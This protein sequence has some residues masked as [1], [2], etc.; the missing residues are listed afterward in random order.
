MVIVEI[1]WMD[2]ELPLIYR[3]ELFIFE[4]L[5]QGL[6]LQTNLSLDVIYRYLKV[7][8]TFV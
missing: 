7:V 6:V 5:N 8:I 2:Y 1:W 3:Y 4:I